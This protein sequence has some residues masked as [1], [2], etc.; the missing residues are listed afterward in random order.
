MTWF[1]GAKFL[2]HQIRLFICALMLTAGMV[3][4]WGG[5]QYFLGDLRRRHLRGILIAAAAL[6]GIF[7]LLW[8]AY[9]D[10]VAPATASISGAVMLW[11]GV[12][13]VQAQ[14]R[15]RWLGYTLIARGL[16]NIVSSITLT[17]ELYLVWFAGT[18]L[19]KTLS[20]LGLIYSVQDEI[21]QRYARTIDSLSHGF[22]I[23]DR[24]GYVHVAN[25]RCAS[26]LGFDS[27]SDLVGK[28]VCELL[29]DLTPAIADAYFQR[30]EAK[31]VQYPLTET[32]TFKLHNGV[33]LP[34]EMMGSPYIERGRLYCLI[35]LIDISE[36]KKKDDMLYRAARIDPVTGFFNRHA[37][38]VSLAQE[39]AGAAAAGRE[40]AVL[41]LDLDKFKR[42]NDSFGHAIGDELLR[43]TAHRLYGVLRPDD[44]LARFGGDEFIVVMPDLAPGTAEQMATECAERVIGA[45]ANRFD[46]SHHAIALSASVGVACY[47][48]H[49]SDSDMLIRNADIAMYEA[50]KAGRGELRFFNDAMNAAAKEAL[51]ID[52]A[53]R[54]A[55]EAG[56]FTLLYQPI[57]DARTGKPAKV[58]AL[59]RWHSAALGWVAPDRFIPVAEDSGMIVAIGTWVLNEACRQVARWR[60][61][62][63]G[64]LT[65]SINVSAWQLADPA[66]VGLVEQALASNGLDGHR[67][68]LELTERVLIDDGGQVRAVLRRLRALGVSM[69][70]DDFGTGYSSLSYLTR[71]Q[72]NTL[73]IDRA[74]VMDI[75]HSERSNSL[76]NAIIAMGHSLGLRL[77]AEGVETA[78]Q[79][80]ILETMG[81]HYLQGYY[82]SRPIAPDEL[83]RFAGAR[84]LSAS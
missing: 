79:A 73:K 37:L 36:R 43:Q 38:S 35:Q 81:C 68:E 55:I 42:V 14:Q 49:G 16:F 41:F 4:Y 12:R 47:P 8:N 52:G 64:G 27:P 30:F 25:E 40:C 60:D 22:L 28:H 44:V 5:T 63:L 65:I 29:P 33:K 54:G 62:P 23:R 32:A 67:L 46:L 45:I 9:Y 58:E 20:M 51:V 2:P 72:L 18:S 76:V 50:K 24:R 70:L 82:L 56:E 15:Y 6:T 59:L 77:V 84:R 34:V 39:V 1:V 78:G 71:F 75:E 21:Q 83:L 17:P 10:L 3:G 66:F 11:M 48:L 80:A 61:G 19:L 26:L 69:S 74:F 13:L 53:L 31:G 57:V 7:Y